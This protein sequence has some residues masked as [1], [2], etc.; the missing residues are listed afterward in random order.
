V[1]PAADLVRLPFPAVW[2]DIQVGAIHRLLLS[3]VPGRRAAW[4]NVSD[5]GS[6]LA[7]G[8]REGQEIDRAARYVMKSQGRPPVGP[9][10]FANR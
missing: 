6:R 2:G 3:V 10:H 1:L 9:V 5:G 8:A 4:W 7:P